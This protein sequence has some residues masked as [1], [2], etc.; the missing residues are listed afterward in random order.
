M[1]Q[2]KL[3]YFN[4]RSRAEL[5]RLLFAA[6]RVPYEDVR[7]QFSEWPALKPN[8]PFTQLPIL[9]FDGGTTI[10]QSL[11]IATF[12]ATRFG[13]HGESEVDRLRVEMITGCATDIMQWIARFIAGMATP[14]PTVDP[15]QQKEFDDVK[16]PMFMAKFD[17]MLGDKKYFVA[18]KLT[19]ADIA[20]A[21]T[22][23]W[24][25]LLKFRDPLSGFPRLQALVHR[26]ESTPSIAEWL[27]KRPVTPL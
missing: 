13:L 7:V 21:N 17:Q 19:M 23:S 2:Y 3:T 27:R 18:D 15:A 22:V 10:S 12:L 11:T 5:I 24:V 9:E 4:L 20:F 26:V 6:A 1:A 14:T 16:L 25:M 8:T